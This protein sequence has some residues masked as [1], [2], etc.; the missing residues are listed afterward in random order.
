MR[1]AGGGGGGG[2]VGGRSDELEEIREALAS[3]A[4]RLSDVAIETLREAVAGGETRRPELERRVTRAR[5]A[6]ERAAGIL[7]G[8]EGPEAA[9]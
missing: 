6:V 1:P 7:A 9:S 8:A 2:V 5:H 3:L 4:E